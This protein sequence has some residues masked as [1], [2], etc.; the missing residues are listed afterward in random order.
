MIL[1]TPVAIVAV[2]VYIPNMTIKITRV[3]NVKL[4]ATV[5]AL[6]IMQKIP[7]QMQWSAYLATTV[8]TFITIA[9]TGQLIIILLAVVTVAM[10]A[11][12][13][14]RRWLAR[15]DFVIMRVSQLRVLERV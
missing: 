11:L 9:D 1:A 12:W 8:P 7:A 6:T 3:I 5:A 4:T 13:I 14:A 15:K 10:I 2:V